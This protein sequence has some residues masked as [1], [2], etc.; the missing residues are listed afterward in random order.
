MSESSVVPESA[1]TEVRR[2]Q[3]LAVA[4]A[5][6]LIAA[7]GVMAFL[8]LH[9]KAPPAEAPP[10]EYFDE[11]L[12]EA[13][14]RVDE[15]DPHWHFAELEAAREKVP[16]AENAAPLVM[17]S[18]KLIPPELNALKTRDVRGRLR[19]KGRDAEPRKEIEPARAMLYEARKLAGFSRGRHDVKWNLNNPLATPLAIPLPI[20]LSVTRDVADL[21]LLDAEVLAHEGKPDDALVSVRAALVAAHTVGDEPMLKSQM[22]RLEWQDACADVLEE[23]LRHGQGG[24]AKLLAVQKALEAE[25]AE[26]VMRMA[27][28]AERAGLHGLMMALERD[29]LTREELPL[30]DPRSEGASLL[31]GRRRDTL[32]AVHASLLDYSTQFVEITGRPPAEQLPL[33]KKL[34]ATPLDGPLETMPLLL[35]LPVREIVESCQ[36]AQAR[37]RCAAAGV[38]AERYR[39]ANGRWPDD[40]AALVPK[41]LDAVPADPF[42]GKPLGY[43]AGKLDVTVF[44]S[45]NVAFR[46]TSAES[47]GK[48]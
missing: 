36:K 13:L 12:R 41:Y 48:K 44:A 18:A 27:A 22:A 32:E 9:K 43:A 29:Q 2:R 28:R 20:H 5:L 10:P 45:G 7:V 46:L 1:P 47:R 6:V 31:L 15:A 23:V 4:G 30:L 25:A 38:A 35:A 34:A 11:R 8:V 14:A 40:L 3:V 33:A 42:D 24:E 17:A 26:P 19:T 16:A 37:L 39:V 21:L